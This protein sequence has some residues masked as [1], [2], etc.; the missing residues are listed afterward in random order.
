MRQLISAAA[1]L[2]LVATAAE[3]ATVAA[4]GAQSGRAYYPAAGL[5]PKGKDGWTDD[6]TTGGSTT[7]TRSADGSLDILFRDATGEITSARND[8]ADIV[9]LRKSANEVAV[10]VAYGEGLQ[11]VEV[12]S[13]IRETDGSARMLQLSSKGVSLAMSVPKAGVYV[14][15]CTTLDLDH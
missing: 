6:Q 4:C 15:D 13:F 9:L 1:A 12:Y 8:G 7:L 11:A 2:S 10:L 5:V 3:A 14:A